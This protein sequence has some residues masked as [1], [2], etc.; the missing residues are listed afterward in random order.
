MNQIELKGN[1]LILR[2][3]KSNLFSR[4]VLY[5][6]TILSAALPLVGFFLNLL[7]FGELGF[8]SLMVLLLTWLFCF[9]TLR[10]SLW[11]TYGKE[12]IT[13]SKTKLE[14]TVDYN[15]FKD[16]IKEFDYE[17]ITYTFKQ[18]GYEEDNK[19]VL[20][21]D[22]NNGGVFQRVTKIDIESLNDFISKMNNN[23]S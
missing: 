23:G 22:L 20:V 2:V 18:V 4:I 14:Y 10:I 11:N 19:G 3:K 6:I 5:F 16:K 15:W 21:L 7:S 13:I 1:T 17:Y 12:I 9:L 8:F